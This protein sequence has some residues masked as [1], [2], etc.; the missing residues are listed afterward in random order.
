MTQSFISH[1][2]A[3]RIR[4]LAENDESA[5]DPDAVASIDI[6]HDQATDSIEVGEDG[7]RALRE[8]VEADDWNQEG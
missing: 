1:D 6:I 5:S 4:F 2:S 7:A 8:M 3:V